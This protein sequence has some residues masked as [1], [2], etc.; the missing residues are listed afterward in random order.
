MSCTSTKE[1]K[2]VPDVEIDACSHYP[3]ASR[4][5]VRVT[6]TTARP[7]QAM[8]CRL[9]AGLSP[10]NEVPAVTNADRTGSGLVEITLHLTRNA[11][12]VITA[13]TADFQ[14]ALT[15][16][17][18]GT[19]LTGAHIHPGVAGVNGSVAVNTGIASGEIVLANGSGKFTRNGVSGD[20]S[21]GPEHRVE[22]GRLLFRCAQRAVAGTPHESRCSS[23]VSGLRARR[24]VATGPLVCSRVL[25]NSDAYNADAYPRHFHADR[26]RC[27]GGRDCRIDRYHHPIDSRWLVNEIFREFTTPG[28][29]VAPPVFTKCTSG[30]YRAPAWPSLDHDVRLAPNW[31]LQ[32]LLSRS[33]SRLPAVTPLPKTV[34]YRST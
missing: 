28:S 6:M 1:T 24:P 16:F 2:E 25:V 8:T 26:D 19:T 22:P 33:S 14:V 5:P 17:P 27:V 20:A 18:T 21:H 13:A 7:R 10:F 23:R 15:G 3:C 9:I 30:E 34:S 32:W 31:S 12:G 29:P 4:A 11:A